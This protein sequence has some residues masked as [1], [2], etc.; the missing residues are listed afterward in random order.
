MFGFWNDNLNSTITR[1]HI[2]LRISERALNK[3][4]ADKS[5]VQ[6]SELDDEGVKNDC[7]II[8][9]TLDEFAYLE[10]RWRVTQFKSCK[11]SVLITFLNFIFLET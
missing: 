5:E 10:S 4:T 9:C 8:I 6:V 3:S 1:T 7:G 2:V 11:Q